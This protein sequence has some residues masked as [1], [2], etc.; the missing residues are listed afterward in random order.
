MKRLK[1]SLS[2]MSIGV[3]LQTLSA[4]GGVSSGENLFF[5]EIQTFLDQTEEKEFRNIQSEAGLLPKPEQVGPLLKEE[6]E[7]APPFD[8]NLSRTQKHK[9]AEAHAKKKPQGLIPS[10][11]GLQTKQAQP[12]SQTQE[13][14]IGPPSIQN[15]K[16][17]EALV[18]TQPLVAIAEHDPSDMKSKMSHTSQDSQDKAFGYNTPDF[19][20][21]HR[22]S[23][24]IIS[25]SFIYWKPEQ[26]DFNVGITGPRPGAEQK[27]HEFQS[28]YEPGFKA[29][30]GTNFSYD[31]WVLYL[32]YTDLHVHQSNARG[33]NSRYPMIVSPWVGITEYDQNLY[34]PFASTSNEILH[35]GVSNHWRFNFQMLDLFL[36]RSY[37]VGKKLVF[38][39]FL[40][41][42]GAKINQ[43]LN[44]NFT[45]NTTGRPAVE[46]IIYSHNKNN[47]QQIGPRFGLDMNWLVGSNFRFGGTVAGALLY[48]QYQLR[49]T[50]VLN[51]ASHSNIHSDP[52]AFRFN[53]DMALQLGWRAYMSRHRRSIDLCFKYEALGF[54]QQNRVAGLTHSLTDQGRTLEGGNLYLHGGTF[55]LEFNF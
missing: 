11:A 41:A 34:L 35:S 12:L 18:V 31:N 54:W 33:S 46:N 28:K 37:Y 3:F 13:A 49:H 50:E 36:S 44:V 7:L 15:Q 53:C 4:D 47:T 51:G 10:N 39:P 55:K 27:V 1:M 24:L 30:I 8:N 9:R 40:A 25:G 52:H 38:N 42:R 43:T 14:Y 17:T 29:G 2:L 32:E 20:S 22:G 23:G 6:R 48:T 45:Y 16:K 26:D 5:E 21:L 19:A